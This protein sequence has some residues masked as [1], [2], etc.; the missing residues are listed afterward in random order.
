MSD[1]DVLQAQ[2]EQL[3]IIARRFTSQADASRLITSHVRRDMTRLR[4][5]WSGRGA[6]AFLQEME[7]EVLPALKR[8]ID[9]LDKAN[10]TVYAIC[11]TLQAAE[12]EAEALF[13]GTSNSESEGKGFWGHFGD[14]FSGM[15]AELSDTVTGLISVIKDPVAAAQGLWYGITHPSE[16]WDAFKQPYVE[17]WNNGRPWRAIGRGTMALITTLIGTKGADKA[18]KF[19]RGSRVAAAVTRVGTRVGRLPIDDV[20]TRLARSSDDAARLS[21]DIV[22]GIS[23]GDNVSTLVDDLARQSSHVLDTPT[24][25]LPERV[26]LGRWRDGGVDGYYIRQAHG[27]GGIVYST[28]DDVWRNLDNI[29][30]PIVR[31][32]TQWDVNRSFLQQQID[33]GVP[34]IEYVSSDFDNILTTYKG[35]SYTQVMDDFINGRPNVMG[36]DIRFGDLEI[37]YLRDNASRFGYD[38]IDNAWVKR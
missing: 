36:N 30:D 19:A 13:K 1:A 11:T 2:Y 35:Q 23:A 6:V 8:L 15:W 9:A 12:R 7:G 38:F 29:A 21:N 14:F 28:G 20:L 4:D 32:Q 17:D 27:P 24:G 37:L 16:L 33:S 26:V 5:S 34:R 18:I 25:A 3:E 31:R 22:R 10:H